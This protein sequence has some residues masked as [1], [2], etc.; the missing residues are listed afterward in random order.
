[1]E[2]VRLMAHLVAG[3]PDKEGCHAVAQGLVEGGASYLEVQIP[4]SD[5]SADGPAIRDAC[6]RSLASGYTVQDSLDFIAELNKAYPDVP[7]FVMAYASLLVTPGTAAFV[8]AMAR[9]AV[10]GLIVPDLPF[11]NDE[12][13]AEACAAASSNG[14]SINAVPVAAPSM[15]KSRLEQMAALGRPYIYAALRT[16]I[17][18]TRT[19]I[20]E[21]TAEF[22]SSCKG[23]SSKVLGGFGI[24][25][26]SQAQ[27][28]APL[29]HA[30]VAG[31]V[32][33]DAVNEA[34]QAFE[35]GRNGSYKG[36]PRVRN[37]A[38]RRAVYDR[39]CELSSGS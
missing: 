35:T 23:G 8:D 24:R 29:V 15:R 11:D 12:G 2:Q 19:E 27:K 39:A 33:V 14:A 25:S 4:F 5:P 22:L 21:G 32:F 36:S 7:V 26:G 37:E 10:R 16:G 13:L 6:A 30:V 1:M 9:R 28:I 31:S 18:G 34:I 17:T 3:F 38:I 20:D